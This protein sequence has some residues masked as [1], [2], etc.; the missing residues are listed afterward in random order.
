MPLQPFEK[1]LLSFFIKGGK[2]SFFNIK[3]ICLLITKR[4]LL[5]ITR[6][7]TIGDEDINIDT[8]FELM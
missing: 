6:Y 8:A 4:I 2:R 5:K 3:A 7:Q 1:P